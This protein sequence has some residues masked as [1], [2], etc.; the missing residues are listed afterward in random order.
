METP[1]TLYCCY[2]CGATTY[3]PIKHQEAGEW[4]CPV[5]GD[6]NCLFPY[7]KGVLHG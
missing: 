6:V 4:F 7:D 3:S 5:C 2:C 1:N